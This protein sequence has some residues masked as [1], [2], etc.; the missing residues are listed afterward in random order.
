[1]PTFLALVRHWRDATILGLVAAIALIWLAKTA[2]ERRGERLDA[3]LAEMQI[4][5]ERE[6]DQVR[7]RTAIA[8]AEDAARAA[9]IERDQSRISEEVSNAYQ[10]QLADL[11]RRYDAV[12]L[13][14]A[15]AA[16]AASGGGGI[17]PM[18]RLS[19]AADRIDGAAAQDRLPPEDALIAS[20]QALQLKAL[21]DWVRDQQGIER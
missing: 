17:A 14:A 5:I 11:R 15:G 8:R 10:A 4:L 13:H 12:R 2:A 7:A 21:Q 16:A 18:P 9:R 3:R 1:M 6:R 20:E 19:D